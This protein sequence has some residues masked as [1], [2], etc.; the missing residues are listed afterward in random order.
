MAEIEWGHTKRSVPRLRN[1]HLLY[2]THT[3]VASTGTLPCAG[4]VTSKRAV[5][6][7]L[8]LV[9]FFFCW[10][11]LFFFLLVLCP[12]CLAAGRNV[13]GCGKLGGANPGSGLIHKS[14][15]EVWLLLVFL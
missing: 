12:R 14:K 3:R 6:A 5:R 8:L 1:A 2:H 11:G 9:G 7:L 4:A 10:F 13:E 15:C